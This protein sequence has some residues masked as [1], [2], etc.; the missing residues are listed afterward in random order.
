MKWIAK[1]LRT[2][3]FADLLRFLLL[4][5]YT[6]TVAA[7]SLGTF[8]ATADMTCPSS[9][10]SGSTSEWSEIGSGL[11][12]TIAAVKSLAI[13]PASPSTLY[14]VDARG[15][16]FKTID[17]GGSWKLRGSVVGVNFFVADPTDS[18]IIYAATQRGVLKSTDGGESWARADRGLASDYSTTIAIDPLAPAT[19]Y[20]LTTQGIFKSTDAARTWNKLDTLPSDAPYY[21]GG[22]VTIDPVTPS[23]IYVG[24]DTNDAEQGILKSTDGGQSWIRLGNATA[25]SP[26][27][28]VVDPITSS[29]LYARSSK[30]SILKS[31]DGGQTWMV[32][33]VAP[34]GASVYSLAI[35]PVSP[36]TLYA[37]YWGSASPRVSGI[38][39][40]MD[41]GENWSVLD[42]GLPAS[43]DPG[44]RFVGDVPVLAVSPTTPSTVYTGYFHR[45]GSE[46]P[47]D[48]HLVKS[49]DGGVTWNAADAGLSYVDM[50][51]VAIDPMIPSRIY[52]GMAGAGSSIPV[53]ESAD[54]GASWS[55][56]AQFELS[57]PALYGWTSSVLVGFA[58]PNS[59]YAAAQAADGYH[60]VF[61]TEDGGANWTRSG[62]APFGAL[63][64]TV[65]ALDTVDSNTIYLGEYD[66]Y[67]DGEA[68]LYK[69]VDGGST[70]PRSYQ[71]DIGPV[72]ALV[73]DPGNRATLY[74][75]TPEG[76]FQSADG[77]ARWSNIGLS[78]GVSSLA[79]DPGDP[80]TIYAGAGGASYF[81]PGFLG[82]FKSTDG[83]ASWAP[84]NN[85]LATVL[86]LRSTVTAI[87]FAPGNRSTLYV[88]TSGRGV[89][90]SFNG[91]AN[92]APFN[93][94]LTNLD[95]R[96]LAVASNALY[97]VTSSGIF[98]AVL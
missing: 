68:V 90:K 74:A 54:G 38:L 41:S 78:M 53:F 33:S 45:H 96:L 61:K 58:S 76:V 57:D 18:S 35:D 43:P 94:G 55:S 8:T 65:M 91:G 48:G 1:R 14:A 42:T 85:G 82:V 81:G 59:I 70:W 97:A 98:K 87:A 83:G 20:A 22:Q 92:W 23:T 27:G 64:A 88:A 69:S 50:H 63:F 12:R 32:H 19:L 67:G 3:L 26:Y 84:I 39:K 11:P 60:A 4:F 34:P 75:G 28:L 95:V 36:S 52:A 66:P 2:S 6:S 56:L 37:V 89:Y 17:S 25:I 30:G 86:D 5:S 15:R 7:Q 51:T 31:T 29:T 62:P 93:E 13:D 79:L 47:A 77:G 46:F 73:I 72:N 16:L 40:S 44:F 10:A 21:F 80:N 71:W 24:L 9:T 49:T